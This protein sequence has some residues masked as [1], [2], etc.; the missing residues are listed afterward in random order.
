MANVT[1]IRTIANSALSAIAITTNDGAKQMFS[2][3]AGGAWDGA[4]W[5][6]WVGN[7]G[8]MWKCLVLALGNRKLKIYQDYWKPAYQDAVKY[9]WD[10][11]S[12]ED[13]NELGGNNRGGGEKALIIQNEAS[14]IMQ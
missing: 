4:L 3:A 10:N 6:P 9:V 2:V 11:G 7:N 12:Y 14:V 13:G 8:E 5:V 1:N